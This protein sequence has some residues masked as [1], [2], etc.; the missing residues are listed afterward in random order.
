[1]FYQ[2]KVVNGVLH[3]RYHPDSPWSPF[4]AKELTDMLINLRPLR[5]DG[6]SEHVDERPW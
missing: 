5:R 6:Y 4:S 2:E 3:R 1:M